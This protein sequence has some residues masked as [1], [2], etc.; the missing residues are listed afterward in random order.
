MWLLFFFSSPIVLLLILAFVNAQASVQRQKT[1][2][3]HNSLG[4]A[5]KYYRNKENLSYTDVSMQLNMHE[6]EVEKWENNVTEP[7]LSQLQAL[8]KL[9]GIPLDKLVKDFQASTK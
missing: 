3:Q 8:A 4:D 7:T 5:L 1:S 2:P 6:E 9:Y